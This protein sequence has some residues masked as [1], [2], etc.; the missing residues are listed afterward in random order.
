MVGSRLETHR[1]GSFVDPIR[2]RWTCKSCSIIG[3]GYSK[4]C[5]SNLEKR[6]AATRTLLTRFASQDGWF[7]EGLTI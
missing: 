5:D 1:I 3:I 2:V 6:L 4:C 7:E